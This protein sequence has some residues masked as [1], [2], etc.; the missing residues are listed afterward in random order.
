MILK[1]LREREPRSGD[2]FVWEESSMLKSALEELI[3]EGFITKRG[4]RYRLARS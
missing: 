2:E 1:T 3:A 4:D